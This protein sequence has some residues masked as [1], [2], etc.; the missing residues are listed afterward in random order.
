MEE[1]A[2]RAAMRQAARKAGVRFY[3]FFTLYAMSIGKRPG[4]LYEEDL[5]RFVELRGLD[6]WYAIMCADETARKQAEA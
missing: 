3:E 2:R 1:A 5:D 6:N 4:E